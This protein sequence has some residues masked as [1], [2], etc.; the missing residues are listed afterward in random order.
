MGNS[1]D[2]TQ[3]Y[4][5]RKTKKKGTWLL[6]ILR[7]VIIAI[8]GAFVFANIKP[9]ELLAKQFFSGISYSE[10]TNV[11]F[12]IPILGAVLRAIGA[13]FNVGMGFIFWAFVQILELLPLSLFGH[14]AF[15]DNSI[16]RSGA[17]R[18]GENEKDPWE[19]KTAK[20]VGNSLNTETLRFLIIL[21]VTVYVADFFLCL[22]VFPP[23]KGGGDIG[24]LLRVL[25]IGQYSKI[26]WGNIL[27]AITTVGAVEFLFKL[28][29]IIDQILDDLKA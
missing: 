11:L 4:E 9:Y 26:D 28:K 13:M 8:I 5:P 1:R 3:H 2:N 23:V 10:V 29:N 12:N 15:L 22:L 17:K 7:W 19:V 16:A 18:Y 27:R 21:G 24:N 25:Q 20:V 6:T 14:G